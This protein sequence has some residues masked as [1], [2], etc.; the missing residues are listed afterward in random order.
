MNWISSP[1]IASVFSSHY[2][3]TFWDSNLLTLWFAWLLRSQLFA[4]DRDQ[5]C[6]CMAWVR[7]H[8]ADQSSA[9]RSHC[10]PCRSPKAIL[11]SKVEGGG[12]KA[13]SCMSTPFSRYT[14]Q[15]RTHFQN[16]NIKR[17]DWPFFFPCWW[18][19]YFFLV[20]NVAISFVDC[21]ESK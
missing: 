4:F 17:P 18:R 7:L 15:F 10:P 12:K 20:D 14:W 21:G 6:G 13:F 2:R 19:C 1:N 5:S 9:V 3:A 16:S 8:P 11:Y